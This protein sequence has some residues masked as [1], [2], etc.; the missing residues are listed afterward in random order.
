MGWKGGVVNNRTSKQKQHQQ[1]KIINSISNTKKNTMNSAM[2]FCLNPR[3]DTILVYGQRP[4]HA[5]NKNKSIKTQIL[6]VS[7]SAVQVWLRTTTN[8]GWA[9]M[10]CNPSS[11]MGSHGRQSCFTDGLT[12]QAILLHGWAQ[13][14][15]NPA[16]RMGSTGR[17]SCFTDGLKW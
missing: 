12:W 6:I 10:V 3:T 13:L 16:S 11:R 4:K 2:N 9:H 14:A 8:H 7:V 15:G 1:K 5:S 17:P